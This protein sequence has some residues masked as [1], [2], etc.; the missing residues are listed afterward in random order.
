MY[1]IEG[2]DI[3]VKTGQKH[4][5]R[6]EK[7]G[8]EEGRVFSVI[9][10]NGSGKSTLLRIMA[11]LQRPDKGYII[12]KGKKVLAK[13]IIKTRR[14]MAVVFQEPLL[15]DSTVEDN[16]VIGLRIRGVDALSARTRA[17]LWLERFKVAH[18]SKHWARALSGGE[19]QRVSLARTFALE[20]EVIFLDEP[21]VNLDAPTRDQLLVELS[22]VL[23]STGITTFFVSHDFREVAFLADKTVALMEGLPVQEGTPSDIL[24]HP[25]SEKLAR[26]VGVEN[27]WPSVVIEESKDY[28]VV[29]INGL[30]AVVKKAG[31]LK[32]G[33]A[34]AG[35]KI[36][37]ALRGDKMTCKPYGQSIQE[38]GLSS[39]ERSARQNHWKGYVK[40]IFPFGTAVKLIV[41]CGIDVKLSMPSEFL[42]GL[43][44][45]DNVI[46]TFSSDSLSILRDFFPPW[47][48]K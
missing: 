14:R 47:Q 27:I 2:H 29:D 36:K 13:D 32:E 7:V 41:D 3:S 4:I 28:L 39:I 23:H 20:P 9:G 11:L 15:L 31:H 1:I 37:I 8:L 43:K 16:V 38:K 25:A 12:Y 30:K 26:F 10:P 5:L 34:G 17:K 22:G 33:D 19:A 48:S 24:D 40:S 44:V 18:L 35:N 6:I 21:F 46:V 45:K 42:K